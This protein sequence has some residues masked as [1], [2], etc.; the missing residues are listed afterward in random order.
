MSRIASLSI[1]NPV[2]IEAGFDSLSSRNAIPINIEEQI[3]QTEQVFTDVGVPGSKIE[4]L[5]VN[6]L[7]AG[8]IR[9]DTYIQSTGYVAGTTGW[10]IDGAGNAE[11]ANITLTGGAIR[12]G[13]TSFTDSVN[14]GYSID[15]DGIYFGSASDARFLKYNISTGALSVNGGSIDVGTNGYLLGGQ[16]AYD[17]GSGFFLGYSGGAH[18]LSIGDGTPGN[19]LTWD[20][21]TLRVNGSP[22]TSNDIFGSGQDGAFSLDGTNTYATYMTKSGSDYTLIKDTYATDFTLSGTATLTTNGY[23]LFVNGTLTVGASC[24]IKWNGNNGSAGDTAVSNAAVNGGA[25]GAA[26]SSNNLYGSGAGKTGGTSGSGGSAGGSGS[27]GSAGTAGDAITNSFSLSFSSTSGAGGAGG[28]SGSAGGSG[29]ASGATGTISASSI[30][31]YTSIYAVQML[32][33]V[34]G[35]SPAFLKYNSNV[36]GAGGGGGGGGSAGGGV[37]GAGGGGGG[38]G[39]GG[40]TVIICA[41]YVVNSGSIEAKGGAGGAGGAGA[42]GTVSGSGTNNGGGAGGGGGTGGP[43]GIL[44]LIYS[45]LTG[46]GTTSVAGGAGGTGGAGGLKG[47]GAAGGNDGNAGSNGSTGVSGVYVPLIV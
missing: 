28:A 8:D 37:G 36:G 9:V 45:G 46:S 43:G 40:G 12:F 17:T 22:V 14:A 41:R 7:L 29:G 10:R 39:S 32:D 30:R 13:K 21:T 26:L 19:S 35:A 3:I 42:N 2:L 20:G 6:K 25:G 33:I 5:T 47:T 4:N 44:V 1:Q 15:S 38:S 11:F 34:A 23:R 31:P 27:N 18:K 16:T 24:V